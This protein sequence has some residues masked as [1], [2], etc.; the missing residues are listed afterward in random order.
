M[1]DAEIFL[2]ARPAFP[3]SEYPLGPVALAAVAGLL[4]GLT[5][6]TYLG[7]R[8]A[9]PRRLFTVLGLRLLALLVALVTAVRPR[10]GVQDDPKLPSTLLIGIDLSESMSVRDE[11]N[12][13]A[14]IAAVR[15]VLDK[16]GP[17]LDQLK[18]E[19]DVTVQTYQ[20]GPADF[21][22]PTGAYNP[23][24]P[25]DGKRSDYGTY[26]TRTLD[27]WRGTGI[28]RG[29]LVIGDG[30]DNGSGPPAVTAA[31]R[32]KAANGPVHTFVVGTT[33][34]QSDARDVAV[35]DATADP[36]PVPVKTDFTL[37]V[38]LNATGF[39]RARVP[40]RV[41]LDAGDGYKDAAGDTATLAKERDNEVKIP[42]KA[43]DKPGEYKL[44][45]QVPVE[46]V[47]GDAVPANN[48]LETYLT[49][50]K[51]GMRVLVVNRLGYEHAALARVLTPPP[52]AK[53]ANRV[54]LLQV[55]RQ[56][57]GPPT[58]GERELLD[59]DQQQYDVLIVGNVS[60]KQLTAIDP[61]LPERIAEQ[62]TKRGMGLLFT[63]GHATFLGTPGYDNAAGWAGT[64]AIEDILP[65]NLRDRGPYPD[66]LFTAGAAKGYQ[67]LPTAPQADHYL[68]R[69]A[70]GPVQ[71]STDLW[72]RLNVPQN[73]SRFTGLSRM[74]TPKSG[75]TVFALAADERTPRQLPVPLADLKTLPPL[76]VGH[77]IGAGNRGRVLAFAG[78]ET[79]LWQFLGQKADPRTADGLELHARFWRGVVRWLA[80]QEEDEGAAFARPA[81]R[82]VAVRG[83][84]TIE[85]GLRGPG[86]APAVDPTFEV[87]V[88]APGEAESAARPR[89]YFPAADGKF[90][91]PFVPQ[92]PGEYTVKLTATGK[93][94]DGA[95][96]TGE[97][98]AR[99]LAYPEASDEMLRTAAD[100]DFLKAVAAAG[101]GTAH[102]VED[103]PGFLRELAARP[104]DAAKPKPRY[105]PD[106]RRNHSGGFL[107]GW[108]AAFALLLAAEWGLRR[109]WGM[110]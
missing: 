56:D 36:S 45:V 10:V 48:E 89:P 5:L 35:T 20:F 77:Q 81:R 62:V 53:E 23:A 54:A 18:A 26:L 97:A 55:I 17:V 39:P 4:V 6:W 74:G 64:T 21:A 106:W 59:F 47:P 71:A 58:P 19:Q 46:S 11:V 44:R 102:R 43:P 12:T 88:V 72:N 107:P 69:I 73:G 70:P 75:A 25:A 98:T 79:R 33:N 28:I 3:W 61:R 90:N 57:D 67:Y 41:Q 32:W 78:Q 83:E 50:T 92:V 105:L 110:V 91:L 7:H 100:P 80:H 37:T 85:I 29:H 38:R 52:T 30:A 86:G 34:S 51:E 22:E 14:R 49:V 13:Q 94:A 42:L 8:Q 9:T 96:V 108:L 95:A 31:E 27:R 1:S 66:A 101:G 84:Q 68:N 63:G 104:A 93:A 82:R 24:A 103:L 76:L 99:F 2:S 65:V 87:K 60:A 16:C 40:V 109:L 15:R